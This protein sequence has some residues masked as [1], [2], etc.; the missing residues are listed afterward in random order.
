MR[1]LQG[2]KKKG[3]KWPKMTK[4]YVCLS[5]YLRNHT[6]WLW[7]LVHMCKMISPANFFIFQNLNFWGFYGVKGHK[8]DLKLPISV[9]FALRLR[10]CRSYH[11]DFNNDIY[12]CFSLYFLKKYNIVNI[13]VILFL[14]GP[15]Q[16]FFFNNYLFFKFINKCQKAPLSSHVCDFLSYKL[17]K[18]T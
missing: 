12:M 15:L 7:I 2:G 16:Q 9:C 10:N 17:A 3:K 6:S 8:N 4:N 18:H 1:S 14:I 13:K 5:L 11:Q